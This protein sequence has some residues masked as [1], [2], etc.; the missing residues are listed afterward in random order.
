MLEN[1]K[2]GLLTFEMRTKRSSGK[3]LNVPT[4]NRGLSC[5]LIAGSSNVLSHASVSS[6]FGKLRRFSKDY[7]IYEST[8][9]NMLYVG[10][11]K[12]MLGRLR[13]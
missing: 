6:G 5:F 7:E 9:E 10:M 4:P 8:T 12:L 3:S 2:H 1:S 13:G 11:I